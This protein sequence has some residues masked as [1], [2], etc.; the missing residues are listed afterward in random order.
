MPVLHQRDTEPSQ[1]ASR[2]LASCITV[3]P[4][5]QARATVTAALNVSHGI[6]SSGIALVAIV[7]HSPPAKVTFMHRLFEV[8]FSA[9]CST[10]GAGSLLLGSASGAH[11][12]TSAASSKS[13]SSLSA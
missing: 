2:V 9:T 5:T 11:A 8:A 1:P 10:V 13:K 4:T 7:G 12:F 6:Q 3:K